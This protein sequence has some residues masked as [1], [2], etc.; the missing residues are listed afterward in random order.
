MNLPHNIARRTSLRNP[1]QSAG[2]SIV[3][4]LIATAVV[5]VSVGSG[6]PGFKSSVERRQLEGVAA[7]FET[8][9]QYTRSLAVAHNR[10]LRVS[11]DSDAGGSCY[12]I[13]TGAP[14][15]CH[16]ASDGLPVCAANAQAFRAV[17]Q[18]AGGGVQVSSNS[19]SMV[20]EP[21]G[22]TVTPTATV[23][24]TGH[25]GAAVHKIINLL[26]RVR[27]CTPTANLPGY[28]RC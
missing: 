24:V 19:H 3:E 7:Q 10:T 1:R 8:D 27:T 4:C 12:V 26:G 22:G 21:V 23:R 2:L 6:L 25:S 20:F 16:C 15:A 11:F 9:M 18:A 14:N 17:R 13:H 28:K 5:T